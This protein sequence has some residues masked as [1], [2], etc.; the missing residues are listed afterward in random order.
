MRYLSCETW[1]DDR[2][3]N[4]MTWNYYVVSRRIL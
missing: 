3:F 1:S 4:V 2:R